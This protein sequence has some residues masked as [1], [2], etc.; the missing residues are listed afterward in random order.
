MR[1]IDDASQVAD[2]ALL[3]L[4]LN[5]HVAFHEPG[6]PENFFSG[7]VRLNSHTCQ[8]L[9][10]KNGAWGLTYG[11]GALKRAKAVLLMVRGLSKHEIL[12]QLLKQNPALP[13]TY[14]LKHANITILVDREAYGKI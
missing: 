6:L 12:G 9:G 4:G 11:I 1:F 8:N 2:L 10:V 13:A 3:G 14:L 7:C 5:G